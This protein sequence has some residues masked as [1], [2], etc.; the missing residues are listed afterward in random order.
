MIV[1]KQTNGKI[2]YKTVPVDNEIWNMFKGLCWIKNKNLAKE[3]NHILSE[4]NK[5]SI[6]TNG[7]VL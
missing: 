6:G 7:E 3:L 1:N 5:K 2:K 4:Y